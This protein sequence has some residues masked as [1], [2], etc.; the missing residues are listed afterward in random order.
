MKATAQKKTFEPRHD[1]TNKVTACSAK[2]QISLC[3]HPVWSESSLCAQW[4]AQDPRFLDADSEDSDQTERMPRLIWVFAGRT[5]I[6]LVLSWDGSFED[7]IHSLGW[8]YLVIDALTDCNDSNLIVWVRGGR[9]FVCFFFGNNMLRQ[10]ASELFKEQ[11]QSY[12]TSLHGHIG[13]SLCFHIVREY[14]NMQINELQ[15]SVAL[16]KRLFW[17][18]YKEPSLH[19]HLSHGVRKPVFAICEQQMRRS[20]CTFSQ[21]DQRLRCSLLR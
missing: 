2:T 1:Q 14:A 10:I 6:L 18:E 13:H 8:Q 7:H 19:D 4:I 5:L 17:H 11:I 21:S 9:F 12:L 20:A 15:P 16:N 3:I